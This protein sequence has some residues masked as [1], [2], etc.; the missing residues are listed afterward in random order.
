MPKI[1]LKCL[2]CGKPVEW[3]DQMPVLASCPRCADEDPEFEK[4]DGTVSKP[5]PPEDKPKRKLNV[6]RRV[7]EE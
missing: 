6:P 1:T 2:G 5:N 3:D 7:R 4:P